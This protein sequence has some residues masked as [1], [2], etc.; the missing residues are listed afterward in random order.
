M[1]DDRGRR[2]V[3]LQL[4]VALGDLP[5]DCREQPVLHHRSLRVVDHLA[6]REFQRA[7]VHNQRDG[8]F[9]QRIRGS[10]IVADH[11][12]RRLGSTR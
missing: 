11:L 8:R 4:A 7:R 12:P 2:R 9:Q 5:Y 3:P 6:N 10:I 1:K